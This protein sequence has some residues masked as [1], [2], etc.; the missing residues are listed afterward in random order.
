MTDLIQMSA[1]S[2]SLGM[3]MP[4]TVIMPESVTSRPARVL[5]LLH[6]LSDDNTVWA[7]RTNIEQYADSVGDLCVVMPTTHRAWYTNTEA[8]QNYWNYISEELPK[9]I[10]AYFNISSKREDTFAAGISMGGYGA[11][12]LGL[13]K[14][15]N[16]KAIYGISGAYDLEVNKNIFAEHRTVFGAKPKAE[17]DVFQLVNDIDKTKQYPDFHLFCGDDDPFTDVN[18]RFI[19][20][21]KK[22]D[23]SADLSIK[24][25]GHHWVYWDKTIAEICRLI[26]AAK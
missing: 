1:W 24:E 8:P 13:R 26:G 2:D 12:K 4:L 3:Y 22:A 21:M 7:R 5:Y 23:L 10:S 18:K 15:E 6:G 25:G 9:K 14:P 19:E 16:Y 17:D 20:E 11:V